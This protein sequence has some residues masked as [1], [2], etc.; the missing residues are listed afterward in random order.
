METGHGTI[1]SCLTFK[2]Y[3]RIFVSDFW[4]MSWCPSVALTSLFSM[5]G[6]LW[7]THTACVVGE[8]IISVSHWVSTADFVLYLV[9]NFVIICSSL[10]IETLAQS[11]VIHPLSPPSPCDQKRQLLQECCRSLKSCVNRK[12]TNCQVGNCVERVGVG[13]V[14]GLG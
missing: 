7:L 3:R 14:L 4:P 13:L 8:N 12:K 1:F 10:F 6:F 9:I 5:C 2:T 11:H